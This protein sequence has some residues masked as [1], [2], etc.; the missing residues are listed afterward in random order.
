MRTAFTTRLAGFALAMTV[1]VCACGGGDETGPYIDALSPASAARDD[2]V[3]ISGERFCG[4]GDDAAMTDGTCAMPPAGFVT[5]GADADVVRATVQSW[6]H[7]LITV[8]V[9]QVAPVGAT[10]IIVT[11]NGVASNAVEF[12]V[13][14]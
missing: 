5:L 10:V 9:P 8:T 14:Q 6:K 7:E 11:V 3:E 1:A 13:T 4:D 2:V 12:E